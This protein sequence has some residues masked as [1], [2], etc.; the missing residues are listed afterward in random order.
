MVITLKSK[1]NLHLLRKLWHVLTGLFAFG[2]TIK[3]GWSKYE[4]GLIA[5]FIGLFGAGLELLRFRHERLNQLFLTLAAP[6]AREEERHK[7]SGLTY[8]AFGVSFCFLFYQWDI[9]VISILYLIFCDPL[10]ALVGKL[11]GKKQLAP[12]KTLVGSLTF[13]V[14]G[15]FVNFFY[16]NFQKTDLLD[17]QFIFILAPIVGSCFEFFNFVDDNLSIPI[18]TGFIV[19][20]LYLGLN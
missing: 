7:F 5:G 16:L 4:A 17:D 19:T 6:L 12:N 11:F 10:S 15:L 9:A 18:G 2:I 13:I 1:Q 14:V 3:M 20:L 8:Y